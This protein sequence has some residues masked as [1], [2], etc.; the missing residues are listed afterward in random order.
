MP[1]AG[2]EEHFLARPLLDPRLLNSARRLSQSLLNA[3]VGNKPKNC[4]DDVDCLR[5]PGRIKT[6]AY[7]GHVQYW[8]DFSLPITSNRLAQHRARPLRSDDGLLQ[9]EIGN[10]CHQQNE[11]V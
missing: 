3:P 8:R 4:D 9:D 6:A 11:T 7:P 2:F 5:R 1:R 10:A